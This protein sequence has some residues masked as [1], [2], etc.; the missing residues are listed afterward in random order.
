MSELYFYRPLAAYNGRV[1]KCA[2]ICNGSSIEIANELWIKKSGDPVYLP[3]VAVIDGYKG[4]KITI[5]RNN[6]SNQFFYGDPLPVDNIIVEIE[7]RSVYGNN[8]IYPANDV[9]ERFAALTGKKTLSR[10]DLA[11]IKAL[12]FAVKEIASKKLAA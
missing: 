6:V 1:F 8:K 5:N 10:T 9:A 12:G 4:D 2:G 7:V 11:N 3:G